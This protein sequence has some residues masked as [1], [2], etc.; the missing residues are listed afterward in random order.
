MRNSILSRNGDYG[1]NPRLFLFYGS[2]YIH[3]SLLF[4]LFL[5]FL[6]YRNIVTT[7]SINTSIT[8]NINITI[9]ITILLLGFNIY[10]ESKLEKT[11]ILQ[12]QHTIPLLSMIT[13][14][15]SIPFTYFVR[16]VTIILTL[17]CF[18]FINT[19]SIGVI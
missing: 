12:I 11:N 16:Y 13:S 18:P 9:K 1:A 5:L 10:F 17:L 7:I 19:R 6:L 4:L 2:Y 3:V 15:H 14:P 8:I